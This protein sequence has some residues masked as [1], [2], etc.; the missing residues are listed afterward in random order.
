V[1]VTGRKRLSMV[2]SSGMLEYISPELG[3]VSIDR[4]PIK[5]KVTRGR[6]AQLMVYGLE[7]LQLIITIETVQTHVEID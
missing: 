2:A 7:G 4:S 5:D 6:I 1:S 3:T